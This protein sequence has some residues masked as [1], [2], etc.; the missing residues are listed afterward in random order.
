MMPIPEPP[1]PT[2]YAGRCG[3]CRKALKLGMYRRCE[4]GAIHC[5]KKCHGLHLALHRVQVMREA[6]GDAR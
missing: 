5:I 1:L 2:G 6:R 3:A 4:C